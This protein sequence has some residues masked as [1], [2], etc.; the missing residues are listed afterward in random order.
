MAARHR[1]RRSLRLRITAG[2]LVVVVAALAGAGLLLIYAVQREM[3]AQ[4]D[5]TLTANAD[6]IDRSMKSG[7]GLPVRAGP[8]DLYVQFVAP[9]G[10]VL[11]S[12]TSAR[13]L[14]A[15]GRVRA[16]KPRQIVS[17]HSPVLGDLRVLVTNAPAPPN[18]LLV[19]ARSASDV[20]DVRSS[21]VRLLVVMGAAGSVMLAFLI[22]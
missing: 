18:V 21:L 14:A 10:R 19:V 20:A 7:E 2:A 3:V 12:S 15:L 11:G 9:D 8:T 6:F 13:G 1:R 16:A 5:S 22:W 17:T 4:I